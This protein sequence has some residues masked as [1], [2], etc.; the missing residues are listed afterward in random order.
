MSFA[1]VRRSHL[2]VVCTSVV[3]RSYIGRTSV[4]QRPYIGRTSVPSFAIIQRSSEYQFAAFSAVDL[5]A[6]RLQCHAGSD[7]ARR[8]TPRAGHVVTPV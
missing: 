3:R 1:V 8:V 5:C 7:S 4:V 6:A 2:Y